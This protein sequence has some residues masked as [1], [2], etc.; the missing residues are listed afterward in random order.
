MSNAGM[1]KLMQGNHD[2]LSQEKLGRVMRGCGMSGSAVYIKSCDS[3]N[4]HARRL[5][6][7]G[8]LDMSCVL[9][10]EQTAGRGRAGRSWL[11]TAGKGLYVSIY[12]VHG[13][14]AQLAPMMALLSAVAVC[15]ALSAL[16]ADAM[17]KWPN[18]IVIGSKKVCGILVEGG[19]G[20]SIAGIGVNVSGA[21]GDFAGELSDKATS[22]SICGVD[23]TRLQVLSALLCSYVKNYNALLSGGREEILKKYRLLCV[24][25][26]G[27]VMVHERERSFRARAVDITEDGALIVLEEGEVKTKKVYAGDV[28]VRGIMGYV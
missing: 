16:G 22:L 28:S 18:D 21:Q 15:E 4:L 5:R 10:A 20:W 27:E 7:Q 12:S 1:V 23:A 11:S 8:L 17:I 6:D 25:I 13:L 3:T 14:P 24:N 9:A 19:Q 26:G 2:L